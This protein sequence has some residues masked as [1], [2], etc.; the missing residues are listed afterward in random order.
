MAAFTQNKLGISADELNQIADALVGMGQPDSII[1]ACAARDRHVRDTTA[2]YIVPEPTL[3]RLW[4]P[5][6]VWDLYTLLPGEIPNNRQKAYDE[7]MAELKDIRDGKYP[8]YPLATVQP[9][10]FAQSAAKWGGEKQF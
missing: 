1:T 6:V 5:L 7:A 8:Q 9:T 10:G 4:G 3:Q 2:K